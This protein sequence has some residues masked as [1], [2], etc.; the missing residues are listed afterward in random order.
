MRFDAHAEAI[1][2]LRYLGA[3]VPKPTGPRRS[4][5]G[6]ALGQ[7]GHGHLL[8]PLHRAHL[9]EASSGNLLAAFQFAE[10]EAQINPVDMQGQAVA[11]V[12]LDARGKYDF[13]SGLEDLGSLVP[14]FSE[15]VLP[16]SRPYD[17]AHLSI[18]ASFGFFDQIEV[19]RFLPNALRNA[20]NF[21]FYQPTLVSRRPFQSLADGARHLAQGVHFGFG[22]GV[23]G[24]QRWRD[25]SAKCTTASGKK[26]HGFIKG[27]LC[28]KTIRIMSTKARLL[29][30]AIVVLCIGL[31]FY[32]KPAPD[33]STEAAAQQV[34]AEVL[35]TGMSTGQVSHYLNEVISVTGVV[36]SVEGQTVM[37]QPGIACRM[38]GDFDA[39]RVGEIVAVKGRV[40]GFD[41]MFGEVQLDF[42]VVQ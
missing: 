12:E 42:A 1:R 36:Q 14:Q 17:A 13:R 25:W 28:F 4:H 41:D 16:S 15:D 39:P 37:L 10:H 31:F 21:R 11:F 30:A 9:F 34:G 27:Y 3:E 23:G 33:R 5:Q 38:E 2:V 18:L 8:V 35:F 6:D 40:L 26:E 24:V 32:F 19:D 22:L 20:E 7:R 29:I